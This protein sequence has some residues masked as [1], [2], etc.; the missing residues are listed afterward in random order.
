MA[1]DF[2]SFESWL[3]SIKDIM[4]YD[5][6]YSHVNGGKFKSVSAGVFK[7]GA[8][9]VDIRDGYLSSNITGNG[10]RWAA[11]L[12]LAYVKDCRKKGVEPGPFTD[13]W[14]DVEDDGE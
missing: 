8:D 11:F 3:G 5:I 2:S 6:K 9:S 4:R 14:N 12:Y 7:W 1:K 13:E 10:A